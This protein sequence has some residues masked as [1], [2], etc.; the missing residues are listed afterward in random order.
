M[1]LVKMIQIEGVGKVHGIFSSKYVK[2]RVDIGNLTMMAFS[3]HLPDGEY[4]LTVIHKFCVFKS[5]RTKFT[6]IFRVQVKRG[7]PLGF[8]PR[9]CVASDYRHT[10]NN[11]GYWLNIDGL[12]NLSNYGYNF[13]G[14]VYIQKNNCTAPYKTTE[15]VH[16]ILEGRRVLFI[17]DSNFQD[18]IRNMLEIF[19]NL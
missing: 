6:T 8:R 15:E 17:G 3:R 18:H 7:I 19:R 14:W 13:K 10:P 1:S 9:N 2:A 12:T 11:F 4:K 5:A 16:K